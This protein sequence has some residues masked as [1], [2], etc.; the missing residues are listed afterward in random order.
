[1]AVKRKSLAE[2]KKDIGEAIKAINKDAGE[3]IIGTLNDAEIAEKLVIDYIPTPSLK[4]NNAIGGGIPRGKFTLVS[5][6]QDSG[7]TM[8]NLE[9]IADNIKKDPDFVGA[10]FESENSLEESSI[11]MFG[12]TDEDLKERFI[13]MNV[14]NMPAEKVLDYVIRMAHSGVDMIVI[15]SLKA[16][17]PEK[18]FKDSMED[19]NV[20]LQARLN[21]KFMR[22]II[23]TIAA[24]GSALVCIQHYT[25]DI[26][27]FSMGDNKSVAGGL[28][29][30]YHNMLTIELRKGFIDAKHPL[31][32]VK[33]QYFPVKAK[34]TKNHCVTDRNVYVTTDY[35]VKIGQG[36]DAT[37]EIFEVVFD[38][39]IVVKTG[40]WIREYEPDKEPVKG[41]ERILEDGTKAA[42][43]G[44]AKFVEYVNTHPEYY[45]YLKSRVDAVDIKAESLSEEE[46]EE[47]KEQ[48]VYEAQEVEKLEAM[49][50]ESMDN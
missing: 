50:D 34:I 29:I 13:F 23:P 35:A 24:S 44:M 31:H 5:G 20:A 41:N 2:R 33:D 27:G 15:N 11:K 45:E 47:I 14:D 19:N 48:E 30:K 42:W 43:C 7:K 28:S 21:A 37:Q 26:G 12:I 6:N 17:T 1:M 32:A 16:L 9:T 10:W 25:T 3:T 49:L 4:L 38:K 18:E 36:I 46:I 22:V 8:L 40:A 39:G